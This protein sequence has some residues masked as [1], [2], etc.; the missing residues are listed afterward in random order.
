MQAEAG[1][2][3]ADAAMNDMAKIGINI[4]GFIV[5]SIDWSGRAPDTQSAS[6]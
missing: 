5:F 2:N 3:E 4:L 6:V 1:V